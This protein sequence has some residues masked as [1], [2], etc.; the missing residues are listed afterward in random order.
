MEYKN[1]EYLKIIIFHILR[2][3]EEK[4]NK[5]KL[6]KRNKNQISYNEVYLRYWIDQ[7]K[8]IID[9]FMA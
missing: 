4:Y 1:R 7:N 5:D 8:I 9:N 3:I 6:M 2:E